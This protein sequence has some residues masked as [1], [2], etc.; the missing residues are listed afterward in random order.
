MR[1]VEH[2][3]AEI[4]ASQWGMVTTAQAA[5]AGVSRLT[6]ARSEERGALERLTQGVY[7]DTAAPNDVSEELKAAWL[8]TDPTRLAE[9]RLRD[10]E[11]GVVISGESAASLHGIG[12][13]RALHHE[14]T[15]PTRRQT[16]RREI[17]Y[18]QRALDRK[19]ITIVAGLPVTTIERTIADLVE[20]RTDLSLLAAVVRDATRKTSLDRQRLLELL[21]PLAA[22]NGF[23]DGD[24]EAF[25]EH[26]LT[27]AGVDT[28]SLAKQ[29]VAIPGIADA[30]TA[31]FAT[32]PIAT[33]ANRALAP[34]GEM[35]KLVSIASHSRGFDDVG[36]R[37]H[38]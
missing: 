15:V 34:L 29:L 33:Q 32:R 2:A 18:R 4:T 31:A 28:V 25:L 7:R 35:A 17:R 13:I 22:R 9:E 27:A 1:E 38:R 14:F 20:A 19:D 36:E 26:I 16:Q 30:I 24:A 10:A 5:R 11:K 12:D 23:N 21:E 6:L 37:S 3:L 8:S